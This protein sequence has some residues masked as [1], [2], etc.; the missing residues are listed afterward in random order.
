VNQFLQSPVNLLAAVAILSQSGLEKLQFTV[1]T[2][3]VTKSSSPVH[4]G[5]KKVPCLLDG[6]WEQDL[7]RVSVGGFVVFLVTQQAIMRSV[8]IVT[9]C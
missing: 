5:G 3:M 4:Q 7:S 6:C 1:N 9:C 2:I 8:N